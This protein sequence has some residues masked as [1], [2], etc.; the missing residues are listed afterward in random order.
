MGLKVVFSEKKGGGE[1]Y[2]SIATGMR[3]RCWAFFYI[4]KLEGHL[5]SYIFPF[6]L[7][8]AK[9]SGDESSVADSKLLISDPDA[10]WRVIS[11]PDPD[12]ARG[13]FRIRI[14]ILDCEIFVNFSHLKSE[15]TFKGHFCAEIEL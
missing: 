12:P 3:L 13:S 15:C 8:T 5:L 6:P 11:D 4:S 9:F 14:R 1:W 7:A 10:S 2:Q